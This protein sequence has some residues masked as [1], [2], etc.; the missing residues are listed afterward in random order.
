MPSSYYVFS[1]AALALNDNA[2][3]YLENTWMSSYNIRMLMAFLFLYSETRRNAHSKYWGALSFYFIYKSIFNVYARFAGWGGGSV[4]YMYRN[5]QW[6]AKRGKSGS[7]IKFCTATASFFSLLSLKCFS[8][9]LYIYVL[10][11][12]FNS[13]RGWIPIG[14]A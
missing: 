6:A 14:V 4:Y 13:G 2:I 11:F 5:F 7:S 10:D 12:S 9:F 1:C 3:I 8:F